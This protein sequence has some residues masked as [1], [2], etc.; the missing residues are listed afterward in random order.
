MQECFA[1]LLDQAKELD[2][3]EQRTSEA[4]ATAQGWRVL[5]DEAES[6]TYLE[7][8]PPTKLVASQSK[9]TD[10]PQLVPLYP[11]EEGHLYLAIGY[12]VGGLLMI[13]RYIK[14]RNT[15]KRK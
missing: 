15:K 7:P 11:L 9:A 3:L 5:R 13:I 8:P 14:G 4:A 6:K 1:N 12:V 2:E 10:Q